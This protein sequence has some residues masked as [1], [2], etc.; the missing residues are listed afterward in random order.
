MLPTYSDPVPCVLILN[1]ETSYI[2]LKDNGERANVD[3]GAKPPGDFWVCTLGKL[4]IILILHDPDSGFVLEAVQALCVQSQRKSQDGNNIFCKTIDGVEVLH[5]RLLK[6]VSVVNILR[7]QIGSTA[8]FPLQER[9]MIFGDFT[10][11][12]V[13]FL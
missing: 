3:M 10:A 9:G 1:L 5:C 6:L 11:N 13:I 2:F 4:W 12:G 8:E 7:P